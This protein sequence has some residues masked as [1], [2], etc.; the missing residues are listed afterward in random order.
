MPS[1]EMETTLISLARQLNGYISYR[2]PK[3]VCYSKTAKLST[4]AGMTSQEVII[5]ALVEW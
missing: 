5:V 1:F 4:I 3:R 2:K